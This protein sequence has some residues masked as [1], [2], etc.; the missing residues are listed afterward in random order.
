LLTFV[1]LTGNCCGGGHGGLL[2]LNFWDVVK[3][4]LCDFSNGGEGL[5][6]W[7]LEWGLVL[8]RCLE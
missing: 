3:G 4:W 1:A 7:F 2:Q 8:V 5:S 6:G